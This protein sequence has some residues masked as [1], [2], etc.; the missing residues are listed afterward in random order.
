MNRLYQIIAGAATILGATGCN[1]TEKG[2]VG[3]CA[4]A[5]Q[6]IRAMFQNTCKRID[7]D[8]A[9]YGGNLEG[10]LLM[11]D[12]ALQNAGCAF[13]AEEWV[14]GRGAYGGPQDGYGMN[15]KKLNTVGN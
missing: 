1:T 13:G 5:T 14:C 2:Y 8:Y 6:E 7:S 9:L 4:E 10:I 15:V 11:R 12:A 3:K